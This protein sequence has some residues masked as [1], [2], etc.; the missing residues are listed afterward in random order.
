MG[1]KSFFM[2]GSTR[3]SS[4]SVQSW[5]HALAANERA[6]RAPIGTVMSRLA[7]A[8][9]IFAEAWRTLTRQDRMK[10]GPVR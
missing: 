10:D 5:S 2:L 9:Q 7:R 8:R 1:G 6:M 3:A 4:S